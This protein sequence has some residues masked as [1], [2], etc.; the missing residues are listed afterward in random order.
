[1]K[2]LPVEIKTIGQLID[3]LITESAKT[4]HL[5]DKVVDG[6][7]TFEEAQQVQVHNAKRNALVRA[8]D[9]RL[10]EPDIGGKVYGNS[11]L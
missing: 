8:I 3:E 6:T 5:I 10:G 7:A 4:W 9:R 2:P 1:M 11:D